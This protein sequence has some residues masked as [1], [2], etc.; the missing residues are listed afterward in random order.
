MAGVFTYDEPIPTRTLFHDVSRDGM[1]HPSSSAMSN[2]RERMQRGQKGGLPVE[3]DYGA[4]RAAKLKR[5]KED[6]VEG[7]DAEQ[8]LVLKGVPPSWRPADPPVA[9]THRG[10]GAFPPAS[11]SAPQTPNSLPQTPSSQDTR[12]TGPFEEMIQTVEEKEKSVSLPPPTVNA[13]VDTARHVMSPGASATPPPS[14]IH[15][16]TLTQEPTERD[17]RHQKQYEEVW[18]KILLFDNALDHLQTR[19]KT[20]ENYHVSAF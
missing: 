5:A 20:L 15:I 4:S 17:L 19:L 6:L 12:P 14:S 11:A 3:D 8:P 1:H 2:L 7:Q 18:Y 10:V 16:P 9:Q 13:D